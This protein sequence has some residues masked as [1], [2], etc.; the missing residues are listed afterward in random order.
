M[1]IAFPVRIGR[2]RTAAIAVALT[3][4]AAPAARAQSGS[5][6]AADP[7]VDAVFERYGPT[8]PGCALG[9]FRNGRI[10]YARGYGMASLEHDV[11]IGPSSV[12]HVASVSKHFTVAAVALLA[13]EGR[14]SLDDDV[15][16]HVPELHDFGTPI[17]IRHL[18]HHTSGLRDQWDL[19]SMAGWRG[20]DPKS[21][22]DILALLA[23]QREL[24]FAPGE[25]HLY[26]NSGY[27]L[28]A[29]I[30][31][32]VSGQPL[33]QFADE[34]IFQ[35]LGMSATVF[36]DDHNDVIANRTSAYV[37]RGTGF[38]RSMPIYDN[39]GA[40]SLNT[41]IEDLARWDRNFDE[42][43]VGGQSLL[44]VL[45]RQGVLNSGETI[46]Y[47]GALMIGEFGGQRVVEHSG[48]DAGYRAQYMRFPDRQLS[49]A[50]LCN[51]G[52]AN[53][54]ALARQVAVALQLAP[55]PPPP[56]QGTPPPQP[57]QAIPRSL[58]A[59]ERAQF[60][61]E[62]HSPELGVTWR[63]VEEGDG[64]VRRRPRFA[65]TPLTSVN[66]DRFGGALNVVFTRD[67]SGE[68]DGFLVSTGRVLNLR[69]ERR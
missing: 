19:L 41:T 2:G 6:G 42:P 7:R 31:E 43:L 54:T 65:D 12:F 15:R 22:D 37:P 45:H 48:A 49:I 20:G 64:L 24:N 46:T 44:E 57:W 16:R 67:A 3:L 32:R 35:P 5:I 13:A 66:I 68:I 28:L 11:P 30:V 63:I 9:V 51:V 39:V 18:I 4:L 23:G 50:V 52:D 26:S 58:D 47:A 34:R 38:R 53:P 29:I 61:G 25:R 56:G 1:R 33:R 40:T 69:F 17:T 36:L 14:L 27:T 60:A 62:Y 21:M 59:A 8:T 55:A 10:E